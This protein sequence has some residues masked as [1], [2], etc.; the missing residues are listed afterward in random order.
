MN[1]STPPSSPGNAPGRHD[2]SDYMHWAK[3]LQ[4]ARFN[5]GNSGVAAV[6]LRE[7]GA[8]LD[9]IELSGPSFYGWPPLVEALARHLGVS[10]GQVCHAEG[11]S[12]ANYLAMAVTLRPGDEV[13]IE[14]PTYELLVDA[15][16][17]LSAT[18]VR[19]PRP[20]ALDFQ[21]DLNA[22]ASRI[23][24]RT[25]L[26]VLSDL[27]NPS[28]AR[29]APGLASRIA[30]LAEAVGAR[31]LIDEV[32]LDAASVPP[33]P[34]AHRADPRILTT[35]SL[36][37][38][39]GLSGLRCGW[40]VAEPALIERM[41]RLN[42]LLGVIPAHSAERLSLVALRELPR[43]RER[44]AGILEPNR[45]AW[46]AFLAARADQLES[47]PL[48]AGTVTFPRLRHG[49]VEV[50][51]ERLR[52]LEATVTPGSFFSDPQAFRVG[53]GCKPEV[54]EAGLERLGRVLDGMR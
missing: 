24:P 13:L 54:F 35:G 26:I 15:A 47:P 17:H 19:F 18:V 29:L 6:T 10:T 11:T 4:A 31:V 32:Y 16:R 48:E 50:L 39:Y 14:E 9:D 51:C 43:L 8:G 36:T 52:A 42:D 45:R 37:K 12:L 30:D 3:T 44:S 25:R 38:V 5:L 33:P 40:V 1:A 49:S 41:W 2:A 27:H 23:G 53:L 22:L 20:R 7:L 21:P 46:N 28:S 34:T